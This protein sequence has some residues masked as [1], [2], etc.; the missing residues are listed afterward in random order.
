MKRFLLWMLVLCVLLSACSNLSTTTERDS[1]LPDEVEEKVESVSEAQQKSPEGEGIFVT[2]E[3]RT[4][5]ET[6]YDIGIRPSTELQGEVLFDSLSPG[7]TLHANWIPI[8]GYGTVIWFSYPHERVES[9]PFIE[10]YKLIDH[11]EVSI[12]L[13][14]TDALRLTVTLFKQGET[15]KNY[16][17]RYHKD[18]E[19]W[20]L[21]EPEATLYGV[22]ISREQGEALGAVV[23]EDLYYSY[24]P[25]AFFAYEP[26]TEIKYWSRPHADDQSED[27]Y[28]TRPIE[29]LGEEEALN[30]GDVLAIV[31][32]RDYVDYFITYRDK[33]GVEQIHSVFVYYQYPK[34]DSEFPAAYSYPADPDRWEEANIEPALFEKEYSM[35]LVNHTGQTLERVS[36]QIGDKEFLLWENL[37]NGESAQTQWTYTGPPFLRDRYNWAPVFVLEVG[38][39]SVAVDSLKLYSEYIRQEYVWDT[40]EIAFFVEPDG[41]IFC[42]PQEEYWSRETDEENHIRLGTYRYLPQVRRWILCETPGQQL[43]GV[44]MSGEREF[45]ELFPDQQDV[46]YPTLGAQCIMIA[47]DNIYLHDVVMRTREDERVRWEECT[48][49]DKET[50]YTPQDVTLFSLD[51][52]GSPSY[53]YR[54]RG[55]DGNIIRQSVHDQMKDE[56]NGGV[57]NSILVLDDPYVLETYM[58]ED[59]Q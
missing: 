58:L 40:E 22:Y 26:I 59:I 14:E 35:H 28:G 53:Y 33:N 17:Y 12:L 44:G 1:Q 34:I 24:K 30:P 23:P 54:Y 47:S 15:A 51:H 46:K 55:S 5:Q 4:E 19:I 42:S 31:I 36:A 27:R 37:G 16:V 13:E 29:L 32:T 56:N 39:Q 20:H 3:N 6:L 43:F 21:E 50:L 10:H 57:S 7:E 49:S 48:L 52:V 45:R 11:D 8:G 18:W 41:E 25:V 2:A 38:G 9:K